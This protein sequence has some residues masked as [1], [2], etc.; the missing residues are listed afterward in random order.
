MVPASGAGHWR[1]KWAATGAAGSLPSHQAAPA[2][3]LVGSNHAPTAVEG[4]MGVKRKWFVGLTT[5]TSKASVLT[6]CA[7]V[8]DGKS[9]ATAPW[10]P[11][12]LGPQLQAMACERKLGTLP[13]P[14]AL[15]S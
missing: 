12:V 8:I 9:V 5:A 6:T 10:R 14:P 7:A 15:P 3:A 2:A 11:S 4:S 13:P 1:V